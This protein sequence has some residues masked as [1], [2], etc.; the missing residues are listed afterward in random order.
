M[1]S[2]L[3]FF[4]FMYLSFLLFCFQLTSSRQPL[5]HDKEHYALLRF[6]ESLFIHHEYYYS[7]SACST[8]TELWNLEGNGDCCSWEGV[9]CNV[10]TGYVIKLD[11]SSSCLYGSINS[12][13]TLFHLVHLQWLSLAYNNFTNSKIPFGIMNLS[14]L[15]HL[16]LSHS[17]FSGKIP[18][19]MLELSN[20]ESLDLSGY[21]SFDL[22]RYELQL[23]QPGYGLQ[24]QQPDLKSL[25]QKLTNLKVLDLSSVNN[26]SSSQLEVLT[27]L[28]SL[29]FLS[30]QNCNLEGTIPSSLGNLYN[31]IH[32]DLSDNNFGGQIPL[33]ML[34]L[35]QLEYLDL[36]S[37]FNYLL[38]KRLQLRQP[39]GLRSLVDKL[40]NLKWLDL[41]DVNISS[42]IPDSLGNLSSLT[43]LSL[44]EC[45]LQGQIPSEMLELSQLEYLDLS[46]NYDSSLEKTLQ[47]RQPGGLRSLVDKLT[48]L[49]WLDLSWVNISSSIPDS[50]GN[51]SSLTHLSL[52]NCKLQGEIPS[53]MNIPSSIPNSL[54]NLSSLTYLD[55][56]GCN[57]QGTIPSSIGSL[58]KL[59]HLDISRNNFR[60]ELSVQT[61]S[62]V[63]GNLTHLNSLDL[64]YNNFSI[65]NSSS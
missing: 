36:S 6:K 21:W 61:L 42:S 5:C 17:Y 52:Y 28:S 32:L 14:R 55:L 44:R 31:L 4:T 29:K 35:S 57:L 39:G 19:E 45:Q 53:E 18:S 15:S 50:L 56:H 48:N 24:L 12:T 26:I 20:L 9:K 59:V 22:L 43:H 38:G 34:D 2:S 27:N 8:K 11:L 3:S 33:E 40:T 23:Q 54:G 47:L 1:G 16:N 60:G 62:S 51:L 13:S 7:D 65:G 58:T 63:L 49:K 64:S 10:D 30:L 37:N 46:Y 41:S 25:V